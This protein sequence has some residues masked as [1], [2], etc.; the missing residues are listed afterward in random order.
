MTFNQY[1]IKLLQTIAIKT[2]KKNN[3]KLNVAVKNSKIDKY[4][5][6]F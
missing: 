6:I 1:L 3:N 5:R 2:L 4:K